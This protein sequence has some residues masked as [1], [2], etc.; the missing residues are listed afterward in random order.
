MD[1]IKHGWM[2]YAAVYVAAVLTLAA[3]AAAPSA[4]AAARQDDSIGTPRF[5]VEPLNTTLQPNPTTIPYWNSSFTYHGTTYPF[6]MVGTKPGAGSATST[7]PTEIIPLNFVFSNG[8]ALDGTTKVAQTVNSPI[9][10]SS[11]FKSGTTQYGDAIQRASFWNAISTTS[12][13]WHVLY[14]QPHDL[15]TQTIDV[16]ANQGVEFTRSHSGKPIGLISISWF[17]AHL[18]NLLGS[19]Q[20]DPRTRTLP[21]KRS[22]MAFACGCPKGCP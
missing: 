21:R 17:A 6:T 14:A 22:A 16:P 2:Q 13:N 3:T 1:D 20:I 4:R 15:G 5:T 8:V 9:F 7:I 18:Q 11:G 10:Q 19:M 12:P